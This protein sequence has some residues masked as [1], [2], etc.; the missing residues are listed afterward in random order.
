LASFQ[1]R[2]PK[3]P[4]SNTA[5]P[6]THT[7]ITYALRTGP[8][9][10]FAFWRSIQQQPAGQT[11]GRLLDLSKPKLSKIVF[12]ARCYYFFHTEPIKITKSASP[13]TR[14]RSVTRATDKRG[15]TGPKRTL[16]LLMLFSRH[17]PRRLTHH[18]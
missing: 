6:R 14:S 5:S 11:A 2:T 8:Q 3:S 7:K 9:T 13:S 10:S 17:K 1:R 15:S 12:C 18:A 16:Q 4:P